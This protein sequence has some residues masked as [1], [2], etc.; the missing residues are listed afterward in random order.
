M[1]TPAELDLLWTGDAHGEAGVMEGDA[2]GEVEAEEVGDVR[3]IASRAMDM[4]RPDLRRGV[5]SV[6]VAV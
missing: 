3:R 2:H 5:P 4:R 6:C 1:R